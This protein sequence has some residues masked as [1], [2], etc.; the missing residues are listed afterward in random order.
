MTRKTN[1]WTAREAMQATDGKTSGAWVASGVSI[2]SR[3][4]EE[5]DLFIAIE[6]PQAMVMIMCLMRCKMVL[7]RRSCIKFRMAFLLMIRVFLS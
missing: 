1:L 3:T 6:G 4:V 2:D 7:W 5:G